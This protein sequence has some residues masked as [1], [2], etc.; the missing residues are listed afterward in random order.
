MKDFKVIK[1]D[2]GK[3]L[4][5]MSTTLRMFLRSL[6]NHEDFSGPFGNVCGYGLKL[7]YRLKDVHVDTNS[8]RIIKG[9][10]RFARPI[11]Q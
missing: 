10:L 3:I 8:R 7:Q 2:K 1:L 4:L 11:S 6:L 9:F 5:L